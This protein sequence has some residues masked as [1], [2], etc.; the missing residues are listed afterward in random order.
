MRS[1]TTLFATFFLGTFQPH[2]TYS[3]SVRTQKEAEALHRAA[4]ARAGGAMRRAAVL[5]A[6]AVVPLCCS[7]FTLTTGACQL[8]ERPVL[9]QLQVRSSLRNTWAEPAPTCTH[10]LNIEGWIT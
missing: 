4:E 10:I 2:A 8:Q 1:Q 6:T 9:L 3:N 5:L 7:A